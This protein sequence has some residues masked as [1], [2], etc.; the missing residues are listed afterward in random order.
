[1]TA[2]STDA[3]VPNMRTA[4]AQA[5]A[6]ASTRTVSTGVRLLP[7]V[8]VEIYLTLTVVLF[9]YGPWPWPVQDGTKLYL[10]LALAHLALA[11]GYFSAIRKEPH[12]YSGKWKIERIVVVSLIANLM[13]IARRRLPEQAMC[14]LMLLAISNPGEAYASARYLQEDSSGSIVEYVRILLSPILFLLA[15]RQ[16]TIG[17]ILT[18][19]QICCDDRHA[20]VP[21]NL[22]D[23]YQQGNCIFSARKARSSPVCLLGI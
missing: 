2:Y 22:R 23:W 17:S 5:Q 21:V 8:L 20:G 13:L 7:I 4:A 19:C 12:G 6:A 1:M 14:C 10:F 3:K 11:L 15:P 18:I 16:S 9:A